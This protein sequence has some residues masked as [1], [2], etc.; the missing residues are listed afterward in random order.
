MA[1]LATEI[2]FA[3]AVVPYHNATGANY[4]Q[5]HAVAGDTTDGPVIGVTVE[6]DVRIQRGGLHLSGP[7]RLADCQRRRIA[8]RPGHPCAC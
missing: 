6:G 8:R 3:A 1:D 5:V 4:E 7:G 2:N